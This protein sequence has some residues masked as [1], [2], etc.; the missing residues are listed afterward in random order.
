MATQAPLPGHGCGATRPLRLPPALNRPD[1]RIA[2]VITDGIQRGGYCQRVTLPHLD[3]GTG[4]MVTPPHQRYEPVA[5]ATDL[6]FVRTANDRLRPQTVPTAAVT[7]G[8]TRVELHTAL[9]H[10]PANRDNG[11]TLSP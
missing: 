8:P 10:R 1:G 7:P 4:H 3:N 2:D 11:S 6:V 9:T 5:P